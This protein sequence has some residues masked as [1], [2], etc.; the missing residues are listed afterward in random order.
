MRRPHYN[1]YPAHMRLSRDRWLVF[2]EECDG[3]FSVVIQATASV[4]V[5][6]QGVHNIDID[7]TTIECRCIRC[8]DSIE[9]YLKEDERRP[10]IVSRLLNI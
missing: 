3:W 9:H 7:E 6:W 2:C 4:F 8:K 1:D 10:D 5:T